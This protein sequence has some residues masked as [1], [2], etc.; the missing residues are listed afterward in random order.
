MAL[1]PIGST[2]QFEVVAINHLKILEF[3]DILA[4]PA[5]RKTGEKDGLG[6]LAPIHL[7][8][9]WKWLRKS[10]LTVHPKPQ[11]YGVLRRNPT[12]GGAH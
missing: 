12:L 4:F 5:G 11:E 1:L 2:P 3:F 8:L 9:G 10:P 7:F 6:A